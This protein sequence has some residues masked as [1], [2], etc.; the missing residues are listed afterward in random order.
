MKPVCFR[1]AGRVVALFAVCLGA[2]CGESAKSPTVGPSGGSVSA[3]GISLQIPAGALGAETAISITVAG[4][5]PAGALSKL[6]AFEPDGTTFAAPVTISFPVPD[7]T[8]GA[9]I[10]WSK[11]GST[12]EF[13]PLPTTVGDKSATASIT[14][15][16]R[17]YLGPAE[18]GNTFSG[19]LPDSG[20]VIA[21]A[22]SLIGR[23]YFPCS[24]PEGQQTCEPTVK[25]TFFSA[26]QSDYAGF[27]DQMRARADR[28]GS[29]RLVVGVGV[30]GDNEPA[31]GT[32]PVTAEDTYPRGE[33]GFLRLDQSCEPSLELEAVSGTVTVLSFKPRMT[34]S[35]DIVWGNGERAS[36]TFD[37]AECTGLS[38][39]E[40][41]GCVE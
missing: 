36:G 4:D 6:F 37:A 15:F 41:W 21:D 32:Y 8:S 29:A 40:T 31:P 19:S 39:G 11:P 14:H 20:F 10:F 26:F 27:C 17:G 30:A 18:I 12:T 38:G 28:K 1:K 24:I 9:V 25:S 33:A 22:I 13:E 3:E 2:A 35:Y 16:S 7:G 34:G 23:D 5:A